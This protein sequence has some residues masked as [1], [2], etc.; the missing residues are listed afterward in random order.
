MLKRISF[1]ITALF[2]L[3]VTTAYAFNLP[4]TGQTK[5]YRGVSPYDEIPCAGTGQDGAYNI[6]PMSFTDNDNGTVTDNNTSLMWQKQDDGTTYNWYQA[7]GTYD[8]T[9]NP[10]S[11]DVCGSLVLGGYSDWR[12]PTKKELM[13]IVDYSIPSPGPTIN[14]TYFPNTKSYYYWSSTTDAGYYPVF[15]WGVHFGNG[16]DFHFGKN[17]GFYVRCVRGGQS[18]ALFTDNGNGTVTD[19]RTGLMWQ[20]GEPGNMTWDSALSYCEGLPL[21]GHTDWRLPNIKELES[22]NDDTRY[23]PA[24]DTSFF[25]GAYASGY[26]SSTTYAYYPNNAWSV[27]FYVGNGNWDG[28]NGSYYVR[29][30]QG[31][32]SCNHSATPPS[33]AV[34]SSHIQEKLPP[35][36]K[37]FDIR[38]QR[39][40]PRQ[41]L[42]ESQK[43]AV[44]RLKQRLGDTVK[45]YWNRLN[46]KPRSLINY[47][48]HLSVPNADQPTK[49]AFGFLEDNPDLFGLTKDDMSNFKVDS[50]YKNRRNG[51]TYLTLRQYYK[52]IPV[53]QGQIKFTVDNQ[54]RIVYMGGE[55]YPGITILVVSKLSPS[56]A[57]KAAIA[58]TAPSVSF[59]PEIFSL[60]SGVT[61]KTVFK[62][63]LFNKTDA[64]HGASLVIFPSREQLRLAWQVIFH[65]N[66]MERYLILVDANTGE[67]LYRT[68][69]VKF[70]Q[71]LVFEEDPDDGGQITKSFNGDSLASPQGW[72]Y[73]NNGVYSTL[74]GNNTC[75]QE[76]R[77]ANNATGY[78]PSNSNGSYL[79]SFQNAYFT[80]NGT[81]IDTDL[82][83]AIANLFY[84]VNFIHDYF[85]NL[86]FDEA[87]GNFQRDNFGKGGLGNDEVHADVQDGWGTGSEQLCRDKDNNPI[88]C[89]N[90]ANFYT[91]PEGYDPNFGK[92][93]MQMYMFTS[94]SYRNVDG[95]F[96]GKVIIHEYTH[97]LSNRLVGNNA[98]SGK[99]SGAMGEGWGDW[100]AASIFN[101]PVI[102]EY[103]TG[104]TSIGMRK[105]ALNN[106]PLTYGDICTGGVHGGTKT[107][108]EVH[109]DGEIWSA[110]LW[111]L[112][113]KFIDKY[114]YDVGKENVERL[115]VNGMKNSIA[116][117]SML[118]MRDA[119]LS[120]D[121][122]GSDQ[123]IIWSAFACRGMGISAS[124]ID[125]NDQNPV[126]AFDLP[127]GSDC[128][129]KN[130]HCDNDSDGY[131]SL[132]ISG[133]CTGNGC[134]PVGCQKT[135]G[136][137]CNDN[138]P[139]INP[140][141]SDTNCN[142]IDEN[143]NGIA[144]DGYVP[145]NTTCG[146]GACSSTG[147]LICVN[148]STQDTCSSGT[149]QTEICNGI[150]DNCDGQTDEGGVCGS[151]G[152][153]LIIYSLTVP[154]SGIPGSTITV[155]DTTKN[156]GT[157][158]SGASTTKFYWSTNSM[159]DAGDTLL[160]SRAIPSLPPGGTSSGTTTVTVP[161]GACSGTFY[162][163][164]K[165]DADNVIAE[166]KETNNTKYKSIKTGPDI[167]VSAV[168]APLTSGAGKT[169][170]VTDTTKNQG[171]CPAVAST[172][173]LYFSTNST[174]DAGDTYL[175]ERAVLPLAVGETNPGTTSVTIPAGTTTGTRYIIAKADANAVVAETSETNNKKSKSIKIGPD[176][177][178]S[179]ITAPTSAVRGSTISVTDTT[180]NSGGGDAGASTTKLYLSTNTTW[181]AGDTYLGSRS[182]PMLTAGTSSAGSTSVTIPSG[183]ATGPYYI[184]ALAD[185]GNAVVESNENNN[186]KTKKITIY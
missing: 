108:C 63:G 86:D 8:A 139:A 127:D 76:D 11:T 106:N 166:T 96:D 167:I 98:L 26:W 80:S 85:Y 168:T 61:Q 132:L 134:V 21:G 101:D 173:K 159:W 74:G 4:D 36:L 90:N 112:R 109:D 141:A 57:L 65:K 54:G 78:S 100:F 77:D 154:L 153:D 158:T 17:M 31:G 48:G 69:M 66:S 58:N 126:E 169:I 43:N 49:I 147:Q 56:E 9:Y 91:P 118:N 42:T 44:T 161:T 12:L 145:T 68:N 50:E 67:I 157:G 28:K 22:I 94:P 177:I 64:F 170:S 163:I 15:A 89:R 136:D 160:G 7:S 119:I 144:D 34:T 162:I 181:D 137:D 41:V 172:T 128:R 3:F 186:K 51:V 39:E 122:G 129:I 105:Y 179:L 130:Y 152:A 46:A 93:R 120:A 110:T 149:P 142:G 82:D 140:S 175:G 1:L 103:V 16:S 97:G 133:I 155:K 180:K 107:N 84:H 45:V 114:G 73:Q 13:S 102:G 24:I 176:L 59:E 40:T 27:Y 88:L 35:S 37:D 70:A 143:C 23:N 116:N 71:G 178:V 115:V 30:V 14:A 79:Y 95:D 29:C 185:D 38:V 113:E 75:A 5:C 25:P 146:I 10:G 92:P 87:A 72:L 60:P 151:T 183:I 121:T 55:Y 131:I 33:S 53:F 182:A 135:P 62:K 124:T 6:N 164:A 19:S 81:D 138:D 171:G 150:D 184:I 117:P 156:I 104:I 174:W 125:H 47:G 32:Q 52:D 83:A 148:G 18:A 99:Q 165:A 111:D 123:D 2:L 20:Q